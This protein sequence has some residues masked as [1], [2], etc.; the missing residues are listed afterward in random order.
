MYTNVGGTVAVSGGQRGDE[1][2]APQIGTN[3]HD[4]SGT[5]V[6]QSRVSAISASTDSSDEDD[7]EDI[8]AAVTSMLEDE[9]EEYF[10]EE[11][12]EEDFDGDLPLSD[13]GGSSPGRRSSS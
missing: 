3:Q 13:S 12:E 10:E 5:V 11:E 9:E 2:L 4:S 1:V 8:V 6:R 7:G